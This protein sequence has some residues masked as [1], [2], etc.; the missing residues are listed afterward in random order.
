MKSLACQFFFRYLFSRSAG[1]LIRIISWIGL[2]GIAIGVMSMVVVLSVMNGL[3]ANMKQRLLAVEPHLIFQT[4]QP[5]QQAQLLN[6]FAQDPK[7]DAFLFEEQ[8][9]LVRTSEGFYEGAIAKGMSSEP[10]KKLIQRI[11]ETSKELGYGQPFLENLILKDDQVIVGIGLA[12]SLGIFEDDQIVVVAPDALL[13][14]PSEVPK[15][16]Q[17]TVQEILHAPGVDSKVISQTLFYKTG[18]TFKTLGQTASLKTGVEVRLDD[19]DDYEHYLKIAGP[20]VSVE[21]WVSRNS[22]LFYSLKME[23]F[24]ILIFLS[25]TLL[26]S[27]FAIITV[28]VLLGTEKQRDMGLLMSLGLSPQKTHHLMVSL[29]FMLSG[30][31]L[32]VGFGLG[33]VIS[34]ILGHSNWIRLPD[35]YYDTN[36]PV[37][38]DVMG[39]GGILLLAMC[40]A[41]LSSWLPAFLTVEKSPAI[42]LRT[43]R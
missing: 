24:L 22:D 37:K 4:S 3:G 9:I 32:C 35:I 38:F 34:L 43:K 12:R 40:I 36:I 21:S 25:L 13:L 20:D 11:M 18:K 30:I 8:D 14:P 16:D 10:L 15:F 17:V 5:D 1:S 23:K 6:K 7:A 33:V 29:S 26:I 19:P 42:S 28:L 39:M 27:G 31:G 41:F 2:F